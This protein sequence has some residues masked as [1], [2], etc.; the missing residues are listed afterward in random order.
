MFT[1]VRV[2]SKMTYLS[3]NH[4]ITCTVLEKENARK[5]CQGKST[6]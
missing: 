2:E 6:H 4:D 1:A 5:Y 3:E